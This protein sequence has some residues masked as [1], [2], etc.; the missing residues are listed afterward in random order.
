LHLSIKYFT[1]GFTLIKQIALSMETRNKRE[2]NRI[3][4]SLSSVRLHLEILLSGELS[5]TRIELTVAVGIIEKLEARLSDLIPEQETKPFI[6][7]S[8]TH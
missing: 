3:I 6:K 7:K 2:L 5:E 4:Y 8:R 1:F